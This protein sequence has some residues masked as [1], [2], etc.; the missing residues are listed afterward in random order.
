MYR[1]WE[2]G[3]ERK[4]NMEETPS[5][6]QVEMGV[7][8]KRA[9]LWSNEFHLQESRVGDKVGPKSSKSIN[10]TNRKLYK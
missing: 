5:N 7:G 1:L 3:K 10:K 8:T 9:L 6:T 2:N 4:N